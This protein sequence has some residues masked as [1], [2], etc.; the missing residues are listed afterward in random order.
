MSLWLPE[1]EKVV[2][3]SKRTGDT[4]RHPESP[5]RIILHST[6]GLRTFDYPWPPHF[7]LGLV[8]DQHSLPAGTY[9]WPDGNRKV[10]NGQEIRLQHCD[11]ALTSYA[12][13]HR[14][15]DPDTNHRG[16]HCVQV[17][18]ISKAAWPDEWS[19]KMYALVASWL[20]DI[21]EALPELEPALD[22]YPAYPAEWSEKGSW[23][24]STPFRLTWKEWQ[25]GINGRIGLPFICA[26][27]HVPGNDHW[28]T[29]ALNIERLTGM[30]KAILHPTGAT[31]E[32]RVLRRLRVLEAKVAKLESGGNW[33]PV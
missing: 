27:Q 26:H 11:L 19:D 17:E 22:N 33:K 21:V 28:D 20:A 32:Q 30:A 10:Y 8:G 15:G 25:D 16:S 18:V 31:F 9:W 2:M 29:G 3:P 5:P 13:L 4:P 14:S 7:T 23:G 6:E 1:Y 12:L 24:F